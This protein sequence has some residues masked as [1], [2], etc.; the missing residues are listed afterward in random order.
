MRPYNHGQ[1]I[2]VFFIAVVLTFI[3]V[4]GR[5]FRAL[6]AEQGL[7]DMLVNTIF[8]DSRGYVWFGTG[9]GLD[10]FDG[11][12]LLNYTFSETSGEPRRITSVAEGSDGRIFVGSYRGLF[13][14]RSG[15]LVPV[16]SDKINFRVNALVYDRSSKLYIGTQ[17]GL[18]VYDTL[19]DK[20]EQTL[21]RRD[22]LL[23][24]NEVTALAFSG[25]DGLWLATHNNLHHLSLADNGIISR[26]VDADGVIRSIIDLGDRV[27]LGCYGSGLAIF[28]IATATFSKAPMIGNNLVTALGIDPVDPRAIYVATDGEGVFRYKLGGEVTGIPE[29]D[30]LRSKSVY[31]ML[32]DER[33][34]MWAGYYQSG[35]DYTP[36]YNN[37][38][39]VYRRD[40]VLDTR[41]K[42]VRAIA[43]E[44]GRKVVG[45]R[46]GLYYIDE[47]DGRTAY[48][49]TPDI[50]SNIIFCIT[51]HKGNYYVGT[52][53]GG[54]YVLDPAML[55][56]RD[57]APG[58]APFV[59]GTVFAIAI[60]PDESMWVGTSDGLF[61]FRDAYPDEHYTS[62]NSQLPAG[63][64]YEIFFDSE[65]RGWVCA[66]GGMAVWNGSSLQAD[67]FPEGFANKLKI[68][69]ICETADGDLY[70]APD[71]GPVFRSNM[72]LTNFSFLPDFSTSGSTATTFITQDDD[73]NLWFGTE[74]GLLMEDGKG[75]LHWFNNVD[76]LPDIVFTLCPPVT[77]SAGNMWLGNAHGL[78]K[79]DKLRLK[80]SLAG[81]HRAPRITDIQINGV[82]AADRM[83]KR[84][85]KTSLELSDGETG[86]SVGYSDLAY[87][88]PL[89]GQLQYR[90][91]GVD[92]TWKTASG[93]KPI[94]YFA[95]P[96]G[97]SALH[98]RYPGNPDTEVVLHISR[99][100]KISWTVWA[101]ILLT[102]L[103]VGAVSW[104][105]RRHRVHRVRLM[106]LEAEAAEA[107]SSAAAAEEAKK[108]NRYRTTRLSE[109]E[110]R[111]ILKVLDG[112]M[113]KDK[114]YTNTELKS[115]DLAALAGRTSHDLSFI[116]N[117]YLNKS[118][119]DYVNEYRVAEFKELVACTDT[120]RYT[121][122]A[123]A[124]RCGFSSRASFFR[125]F[126]AITGQTPAEY[127]KSRP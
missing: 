26:P 13:E 115:S 51:A 103:L 34:L 7:S 27:F 46:E 39:E 80:S 16:L 73:H 79:L 61:R 88:D 22:V 31:S 76:G 119:Y 55:S 89:Y 60:G 97:E 36:Y 47:K 74:K 87:S 124:Q 67:R 50:R 85:G 122:S 63:N 81:M 45:T 58:K 116:F 10:R 24:D 78:V 65:G 125:H 105:S 41:S 54:M 53:N 18:F 9:M 38:F 49:H 64:V 68:R 93:G 98:M 52:Y 112:I 113:K 96:T 108:R 111:R 71:R 91:D 110:C 6:S 75:R 118:F 120:S 44:D 33:G 82:S 23:S 3:N 19:A 95:I 90:L 107:A 62:A 114:P 77:D 17:Q 101:M 121:L 28:D 117:Q 104:Y 109:E 106:R 5:D 83:R 102:L 84:D 11:N 8:K 15:R 99:G 20:L 86:I 30:R 57:F 100:F 42:A 37:V 29:N 66:E 1:Y 25:G 4:Q 126:K 21:I 72:A 70:F 59:R 48:F 127:M 123:L 12:N 94:T 35:V 14:A 2:L 69:D 32:V 92:D 43:V 40:G 56:L